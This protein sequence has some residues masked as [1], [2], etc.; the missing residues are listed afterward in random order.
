VIM[1]ALRGLS[2]TTQPLPPFESRCLLLG[3]E[4]LS[5]RRKLAAGLYVRDILCGMIE[6]AYL[7]D[8]LRF[9]SNPYTR[10]ENARLMEFYHRTNYGQNEP[11]N[12]AILIF[13][14]Y[15]GFFGFC[16]DEKWYVFRN[17]FSRAL[18]EEQ[19]HLL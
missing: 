14:E 6:S 1:V 12:K 15:C 5:D 17:G 16:H 19:S 8:L 18:S 7:T 4:V 2:W 13:N 9:E 10:R 11:I 3:L